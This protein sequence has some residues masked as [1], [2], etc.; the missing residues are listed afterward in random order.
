MRTY[1]TVFA[2]EPFTTAMARD[3]GLTR[4]KLRALLTTDRVRRLLRGVYVDSV[5]SV[6]LRLRARA[7]ALVVPPDVVVCLR[8]AAWLWGVEVSA[9]GAHRSVP[10]IDL[11]RP[12]GSAAPRRLGTAG[13]TG[14]LAAEDVVE[15]GGLRVTSPVRTAVD[16]ARLLARPDA[17]ATLDVFVGLPGVGRAGLAELVEQFA[18]YRG[19][20]QARELVALADARAESPMESRARLRAHDAG[21]PPF[22]PQV[23]VFDGGRFVAR[24]D[25]GRRTERKALEYDGDV[26]H[27]TRR[28]QLHDRRRRQDVE[29]CGWQV[30]V[31]TGEHVNGRGLAFENGVAELLGVGFRLSRH[32]PRRGGWERRWWGA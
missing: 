10:P 31:V 12:A 23:E 26:A 4:Q 9:M 16:I 17:L 6:D 11:M 32:H 22:E 20:A 27:G 18:G 28:Q 21:F 7:L 13:H 24:L 1:A 25:L 5:P 29:R 14:R 8:T 15:L 3:V 2:L 30:A 19:V